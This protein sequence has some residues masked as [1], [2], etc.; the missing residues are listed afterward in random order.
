M[1]YSIFTLLFLGAV[2]AMPFQA[3]ALTI[4]PVKMEIS[5]KPG[6]TVQGE[7]TLFNEEAKTKTLYASTN[8]FESRGE[9]GTPFFLPERTGLATWIKVQDSVVIKSNEEKKI[10]FSVEIPK[11]A[12]PG[13]YFSAILWATTPPQAK[14]GSQVGVGGKLG[15]LVM[16]K[17]AGAVKEGGG[18][19]EFGTKDAQNFFSAA[20]ITFAYRFNNTGGDRVVPK[21]DIML[22]N[23]GFGG[24]KLS[25][26]EKEASVLPDSA[27]KIEVTWGDEKLA[28]QKAGFFGMAGREW[29]DFHM[30]WYTAKL[31]LGWGA[32]T[33]KA[34]VAEYRFF[35]IPWQLILVIIVV[36][37][38]IGFAGT[39][40]LKR[41]NHWIISKASHGG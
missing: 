12:E 23:F 26:N 36:L 11:T 32:A 10:P 40:G 4:S 9:T 22:T 33:H 38:A 16:L 20:P 41:Y 14:K 18:L 17:V 37:G 39:W 25:A 27:R 15:V 13:G 3:H 5:G 2:V 35:V 8:N 24:A 7:L 29:S 28:S 19:L 1:K 21:G 34:V 6:Q 31:N 30:G